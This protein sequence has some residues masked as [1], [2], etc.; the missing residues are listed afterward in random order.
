VNERLAP[1]ERIRRFLIANEPFS[2]VNGQLTPTMKV[3]RHAVR[4]AYGAAFD[5]LYEGKGLAA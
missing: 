1:P 3:R 5:A 4:A 2:T